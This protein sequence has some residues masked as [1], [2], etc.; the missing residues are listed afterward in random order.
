MKK[1]L[2]L[3]VAIT[4]PFAVNAPTFNPF[5]INHFV[6]TSS[7]SRDKKDTPMTISIDDFNK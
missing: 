5:G 3:A 7:V 6:M 4:T 1:I 2:S